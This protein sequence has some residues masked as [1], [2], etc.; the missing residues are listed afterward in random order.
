MNT[1]QTRK[2][3]PAFPARLKTACGLLLGLRPHDLRAAGSFMA[4]MY[5]DQRWLTRFIKDSYYVLKEGWLVF[6]SLI[7]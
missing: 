3:G 6:L 1:E 7:R 5:P 4:R 2:P